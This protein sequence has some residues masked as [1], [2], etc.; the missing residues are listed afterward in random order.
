MVFVLEGNGYIRECRVFSFYSSENM[1]GFGEGGVVITD[2]KQI[3][4]MIH[5]PDIKILTVEDDLLKLDAVVITIV[6]RFDTI[7]DVLSEK[8]NCPVI[9]IEDIL[10]EV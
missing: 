3:I 7:C 9:V 8:L 10:N 4:E 1:G 2:D 5:Y 6:D